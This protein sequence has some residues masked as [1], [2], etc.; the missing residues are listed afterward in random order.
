LK[1]STFSALIPG[2]KKAS[3]LFSWLINSDYHTCSNNSWIIS[4]L[5]WNDYMTKLSTRGRG[6]KNRRA[7][8][9]CS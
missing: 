8:E 1:C 9:H 3:I 5:G 7:R 4:A 6:G 2:S